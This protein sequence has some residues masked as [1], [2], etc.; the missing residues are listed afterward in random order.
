MAHNLTGRRYGKLLVIRRIRTLPNGEVVWGCKCDCGSFVKQVQSK[1]T[2]GTISCSYH[3][4]KIEVLE[5]F[6]EEWLDDLGHRENKMPDPVG[7]G[8]WVHY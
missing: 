6:W 2:E 3:K 5:P 4:K 1:I 8:G 7:L